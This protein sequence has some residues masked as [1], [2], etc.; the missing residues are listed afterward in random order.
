MLMGLLPYSSLHLKPAWETRR[1]PDPEVGSVR[2]P[3]CQPL[4]WDEGRD[5]LPILVKRQRQGV[6]RKGAGKS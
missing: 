5:L 6:Q 2:L 3:H 4:H 1:Q